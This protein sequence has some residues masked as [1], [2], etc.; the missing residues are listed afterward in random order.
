MSE[1]LQRLRA[2]NRY[3]MKLENG[4]PITYRLPLMEE[5]L[6]TR[7]LPLSIVGDIQKRLAG[8]L[9]EDEAEAVVQD[10]MEEQLADYERDFEAKQATVARMIDTIDGEPVTLEPKDTLELPQEN[11]RRLV[12]IAVR[13]EPPGDNDAQ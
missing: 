4:I 7:L 11:F 12:R 9:S 5:L 2:A 6:I 10:T 13:Q 3:D 8:G 1:A